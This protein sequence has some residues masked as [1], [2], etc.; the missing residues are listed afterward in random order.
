MLKEALTKPK[1]SIF[2]GFPAVI[3]I[4]NLDSFSDSDVI[5]K[6]N[7]LLFFIARFKFNIEITK[8]N[9]TPYSL[10]KPEVILRR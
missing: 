3:I 1:P 6:F 2:T 8:A 4:S 7:P 10:Y 9:A 5:S